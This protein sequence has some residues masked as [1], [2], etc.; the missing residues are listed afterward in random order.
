MHFPLVAR[1]FIGSLA[2]L[3]LAGCASGGF[4]DT[5]RSFD[6]VVLDAGHGGY[7]SGA[8]GQGG[9]QEKVVALD[10]AKRVQIKLQAAGI[11]TVMTRSDD[12]FV[13]LSGRTSVLNAQKNAVFV[14]I[15]FNQTRARRIAGV[16][17]Y[18]SHPSARPLA[19]RIQRGL[20]TVALN[21]GVK[22]ARYHVLRNALRPAVLVEC[23][24]VSNR[25][26][27]RLASQAA[28]RDRL[29]DLIAEAIIASHPARTHRGVAAQGTIPTVGGGAL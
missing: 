26:E 4:K 8:V 5:S 7:D 19:E 28:H 24:F 20:C 22:T 14:S 15:H 18:Y 11:A 13:P 27:A 10:V 6:T 17:T 16:E 2:A 3:A 29:A 23:G 25:A 12:R 21:R 9:L 1:A